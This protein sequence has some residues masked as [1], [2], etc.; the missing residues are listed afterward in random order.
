L[1]P[2]VG[3]N[4]KKLPIFIMFFKKFL[5]IKKKNLVQYFS[6]F[7]HMAELSESEHVL[8]KLTNSQAK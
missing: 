5:K 7:G 6:Q 4:K 1:W 3:L 8:Q 2:E